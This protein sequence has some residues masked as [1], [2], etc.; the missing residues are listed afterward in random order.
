[1]QLVSQYIA[2]NLVLVVRFTVRPFF[3]VAAIDMTLV[4]GVTPALF[5]PIRSLLTQLSTT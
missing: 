3:F 2:A 4:Y 1:M 5:Y